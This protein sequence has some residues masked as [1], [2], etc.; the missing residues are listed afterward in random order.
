MMLAA[1]CIAMLLAQ[2]TPVPEEKDSSRVFISE[3]MAQ[4]RSAFPDCDG[5]Y[6]DYIEICNGSDK[7]ADVSGWGLSD[8]PDGRHFY[9]IPD[10]TFLEAGE[11]RLFWCSDM[12]FSISNGEESVYLFNGE[13]KIISQYG[14]VSTLEDQSLISLDGKV[15]MATYNISPGYPNTAAGTAEFNAAVCPFA[16][17]SVYISEVLP[18]TES[19]S[20]WI[21]ISNRGADA[22]SLK[23]YILTDDKPDRHRFVFPDKTIPSGGRILLYA[24]ARGA[25]S[26]GFTFRKSSRLTLWQNDSTRLD[27]V[28]LS[29]IPSGVSKGRENNCP[30]WF[31]YRRPTP[32]SANTGGMGAVALA[33]IASVPSGQYDNIESLTV[34]LLADGVIY[35][36]L[37]GSPPTTSSRRYKEPFMFTKTSV[38]RAMTVADNSINSPISSWTYLINEGHT[39]DVVSLVSAPAGLFS[40]SIGIY[41]T[42]GYELKPIGS[43]DEEGPGIAYPYYEANFWRNW[44]R[45]SNLT[46]IPKD[47]AGFSLDCG[48]SIFGGYSRVN[49]K[50]SMKFKFKRKYGAAKLNYRLF[51]NR[52]FSEYD[53]IVLRAGGQD[54]YGSMIK[55][56]LAAH[57]M[58]TILDVM[59]TK[60]VVYYINGQYYGIYYLREKIN[61]RFIASHYGVPTDNI[62]IIY[63][64]GVQEAGKIRDWIN[65]MNY[66]KSHDL[67]KDE[68]Y[69]W[70][71]DRVDVK[72]Y[73]DWLIAEMYVGN[74]D[75]GN[76][77]IFRSPDIDGKWHWIFYDVDISMGEV[78]SS[79][80]LAF[81]KPTQG[82]NQQTDLIRG[83]LRND[84]FRTLFLERLEFQMHNV[85][86][87]ENMNAGIDW[88][89]Q[90]IEG[91]VARNNKRWQ[92]NYAIWEGK[93]RSL[94]KFAAERQPY[95]KYMFGND[96]YMKTVLH[97]SSEELDRCFE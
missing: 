18:G 35:Y 66:V 90:Q 50:K 95:L 93:I 31:Y 32:G 64:Y 52:D 68:N 81:L 48:A 83:L 51:P 29:G 5:N 30:A 24:D 1:T 69:R 55:D 61:R 14:P 71:C 13:G 75:P 22:V 86:S 7:R 85:W 33:P 89:V 60:P 73:A 53:C 56:D 37:D 76:V 65:L 2:A 47:G 10:S 84:Q 45:Q 59:A 3:I 74:R 23:G 26:A 17:P 11:F 67:S 63:G 72:G 15:F 9:S 4:N 78:R 79:R 8:R 41:S 57:L 27:A 40:N 42:G 16:Y 6:F 92:S 49:S 25:F 46:Y 97:M 20:G 43:E 70:V 94:R 19:S 88:F 77:R 58:D 44:E 96:Y 12:P 54:T 91:E 62:D 34:E 87:E 21:E 28:V 36:T 39:L 80:F 38:L 82:L